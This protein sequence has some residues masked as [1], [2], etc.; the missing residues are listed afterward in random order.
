LT[1]VRSLPYDRPKTTMDAF[2]LCA[3]CRHEYKDPSDRRFHAEPNACPACGPRLHWSTPEARLVGDDA[4]TAAVAA[5]RA[6]AIV[7]VKGVG[8][9]PR[10]CEAPQEPAVARLRARKRRPDKPFA[11]MARSLAEARR[12]AVI[13]VAAEHALT[14]AARPIVLVPARPESGL[15]PSV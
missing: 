14:S 6:G 12:I 5:L 7:A 8:G 1:I 4:L 13:G 11:V 9:F 10:A 2:S 3:E 15:A